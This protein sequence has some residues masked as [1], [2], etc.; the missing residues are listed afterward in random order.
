[1]GK[2]EFSS[3]I[4]YGLPVSSDRISVAYPC[5]VISSE[6]W[7]TSTVGFCGCCCCCAEAGAAAFA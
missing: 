3:A 5:K 6:N 1:M 7:L 4:L 2:T